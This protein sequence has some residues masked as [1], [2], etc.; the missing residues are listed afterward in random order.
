MAAETAVILVRIA[1]VL[2][3]RNATRPRRDANLDWERP[4]HWPANVN[5][6]THTL[7][8]GPFVA[9]L[10]AVPGRSAALVALSLAMFAL[11]GCYSAPTLPLTYSFAIDPSFTGDET[12]SITASLD[13]WIASVPELKLDS[14]ISTC[15]SASPQRVCIVPSYAPTDPEQD[16]VGTTYMGASDS[17]TV[18]LYVDRIAAMGGDT[19]ALREQTAAH[20]VGH[21]FGLKHTQAGQL[22][23][24][25][26]S[27]QAPD[28]TP[29]DLGQFWSLRGR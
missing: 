8:A 13:E 19:P 12:E 15:D 6:F 25:F 22:M 16:V 3:R 26:V 29:A 14:V 5:V 23:A 11:S 18:V 21:A 2:N 28:I 10:G 24:A 20:E 4:V 17:A 9:A 7:R 27:Q 1:H